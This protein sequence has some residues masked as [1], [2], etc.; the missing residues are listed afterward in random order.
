MTT[1]AATG[2]GLIAVLL[3][4]ALAPLTVLAGGIP[5]FQL[6]AMSFTLGALIG[7]AYLAM[8]PRAR[9]ELAQITLPAAALGIGGLLGFHF[10]YF[11]SLS[12]APPLRGQSGQLSLAT[13]DRA[14]LGTVA[15]FGRRAAM[16]SSGGRAD[17]LRRRGF[18]DH[19]RSG[20]TGAASLALSPA[21]AS[22]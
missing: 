8:R 22:R 15:G 1:R 10:F 12:L 11:L 20:D 19:Q 16:A 3:W 21:T 4:S 2:I 13:A 17:G 14:V 5:P 7:F 9:R 18:G 6:V